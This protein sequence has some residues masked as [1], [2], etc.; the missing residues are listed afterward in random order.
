[1]RGPV[2]VVLGAMLVLSN[3]ISVAAASIGAV[4]TQSEEE[5]RMAE[6]AAA[7]A[8]FVLGLAAD[9]LF[10]ALYDWIHP[11][12]H[13]EVPRVT[14][15]RLF[16]AVYEV[17]QAGRGR[18]TDVRIID[19]TWEVT[20]KTYPVAAGVSY[21][22]PYVENGERKLLE[23][24]MFLVEHNDQWRW[25][26]GDSREYIDD[27]IAQFGEGGT[28][29]QAEAERIE[30]VPEDLDAFFHDVLE[31]TDFDYTS[32]GVATVD[33]GDVVDTGCGTTGT[34]FVAFYCPLDEGIY[35]DVPILSEFEARY[36]DF[37]V[38]FVIG[39]EW[40]HHIQAVI[41]IERAEEPEEPGEYYSI[42]IE[43]LADCL[44]GVWARDIDTRGFL[45]PG[46]IDEAIALTIE[47][48]GDPEYI[49]E[50]DPQAHGS[51]D[52]RRQ[53]FLSGYDDGFWGCNV[54]L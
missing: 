38:A 39:H 2:R 47:R 12:A 35:L 14:A 52:Q 21:E 20:G 31:T 40:A 19:W 26:F 1:M 8:E 45:E 5:A 49:D 36:G 18:V 24:E 27:L 23:E 42:D 10:N 28:S 16:E 4:A 51:A 3:L 30:T 11:D 53:S 7:G 17:A 48:L 13:A 33:A 37:A 46:D 32:P 50:Y 44:S 6:E 25:F 34:G 22:Q 29:A 9:R 54:V 15:V 41:G 43:L